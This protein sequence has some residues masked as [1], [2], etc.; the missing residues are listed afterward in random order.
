[1]ELPDHL[2]RYLILIVGVFVI[3]ALFQLGYETGFNYGYL[4]C[5][6]QL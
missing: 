6:S 4:K 5:E 3:V 2:M 1:M